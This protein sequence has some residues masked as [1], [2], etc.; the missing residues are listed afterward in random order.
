MKL[1][2]IEENKEVKRIN[3]SDFR[4]GGFLFHINQILH[5]YGLAIVINVDETNNEIVDVYPAR[6]KF[7]GFS[8]EVNTQEYKKINEYLKNNIDEII[9]DI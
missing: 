4:A 5:P 7:R 6:C 3:W 2:N 8:S 9:K 1:P